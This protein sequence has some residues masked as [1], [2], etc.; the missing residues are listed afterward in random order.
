MF[1]RDRKIIFYLLFLKCFFISICVTKQKD[2]VYKTEVL[3]SYIVLE[4]F[5]FFQNIPSLLMQYSTMLL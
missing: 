1:V 3:L 2:F 5:R 4:H